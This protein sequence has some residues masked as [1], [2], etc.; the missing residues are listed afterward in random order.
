MTITLI[1]QILLALGVPFLAMFQEKKLK[2]SWLSPIVVCYGI[3][4]ALGNIPALE[5]DEELNKNIT[6]GSVLLAIPLLLFSTDLKAFLRNAGKTT[7]GFVLAIVAVLIAS[8]V[9]AFIFASKAPEAPEMAGML[10]GVYTGG[11]LN[12]SAIAVALEVDNELFVLMNISDIVCSGIYLL[13]LTSI[14]KKVFRLILPAYVPKTEAKE[15]AEEGVQFGS[16]NTGRKAGLLGIL[17]LIAGAVVAASVGISML[18]SGGQTPEAMVILLLTA[19]SIGG[20]FIPQLRKLPGSYDY[21]QYLLLVFAVAMG[22]LSDFSQLAENS[23][24]ALTFTIVMFAGALFLHLLLAFIF[25][26]DAETFM[27]TS[28]AAIFGP[29][30]IGHVAA[31]IRNRE[32]IFPGIAA[33]LAGFAIGNFLGVGLAWLLSG[34]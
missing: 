16:L 11:T 15:K 31:A 18:L 13:F 33:G 30:F 5:W 22:M 9:S 24:V 7:L 12:M 8:S 14:A 1:I 10:V 25:R 26:L 32:L 34:T 19:L 27:I 17:T 3:G 6:Q 29:V 4:I 2:L 23:G 20:S 28:T 21:G